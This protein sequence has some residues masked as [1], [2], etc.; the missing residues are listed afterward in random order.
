MHYSA[1]NPEM[2]RNKMKKQYNNG[3]GLSQIRVFVTTETRR[4][5][6]MG[7]EKF[8]C[9]GMECSVSFEDTGGDIWIARPVVADS[10]QMLFE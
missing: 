5:W 3:M 6:I 9:N 4:M 7:E 1:N 10:N 8:K 2:L